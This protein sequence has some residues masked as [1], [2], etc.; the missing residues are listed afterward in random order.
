MSILEKKM[1]NTLNCL[2]IFLP[3]A[4]RGREAA[5]NPVSNSASLQENI[6]PNRTRL[7]LSKFIR[8]STERDNYE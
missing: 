5:L 1:S 4:A 7:V 2:G 6:A 8:N 3:A